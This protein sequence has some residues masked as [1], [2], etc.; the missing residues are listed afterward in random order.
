MIEAALAQQKG[1]GG[2]DTDFEKAAN[3]GEKHSTCF[4]LYQAVRSLKKR[5]NKKEEK[6]RLYSTLEDAFNAHRHKVLSGAT[7][8]HRRRTRSL[9]R[10]DVPASSTTVSTSCPS[11]STAPVAERVRRARLLLGRSYTGT[12]RKQF[13]KGP[14]P[15]PADLDI[16]THAQCH[17]RQLRDSIDHMLLTC[18][19]HRHARQQLTTQLQPLHSPTTPLLPLTLATI[20]CSSPTDAP[21]ALVEPERQRADSGP[22]QHLRHLIRIT[23]TFLDRVAEDRAAA[24][25][26][27][28]DTG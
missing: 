3:H 4:E 28:L 24:G 7:A 17:Q 18:P 23:S 8:T 6:E 11:S 20:L 13:H 10:A 5:D 22:V 16:C 19:R 9:Q 14:A 15:A 12:V 1:S 27:H 2:R 21:R 25:L 26:P